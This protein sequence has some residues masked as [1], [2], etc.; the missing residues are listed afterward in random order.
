MHLTPSPAVRHLPAVHRVPVA[1][2]LLAAVYLA[3]LAV[4]VTAPGERAVAGLVVLAGLTARLLV[5]RRRSTAAAV[6]AASTAVDTVAVPE[7][8]APAPATAA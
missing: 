5:R 2:A 4:A 1:A 3:A 7:V 6:A 8:A